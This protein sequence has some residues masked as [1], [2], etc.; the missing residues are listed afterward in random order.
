MLVRDPSR[1]QILNTN[2]Y[3][4]LLSTSP[5]ESQSERCAAL[6]DSPITYQLYSERP[7]DRPE[8]ILSGSG[9]PAK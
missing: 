4:I 8:A 5:A 1:L 2:V 6:T 3:G 7:K 9:S